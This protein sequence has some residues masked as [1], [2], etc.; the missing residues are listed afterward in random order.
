MLVTTNFKQL[1]YCFDLCS[2]HFVKFQNVI[3]HRANPPLHWID[4]DTCFKLP[5]LIDIGE[6]IN[7]FIQLQISKRTLHK[8]IILLHGRLK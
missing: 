6:F 3:Q 1:Y 4:V 2:R 7:I 8:L 5:S